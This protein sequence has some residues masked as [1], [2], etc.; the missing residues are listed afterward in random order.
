MSTD[1][2]LSIV[3]N[4]WSTLNRTQKSLILACK[5]KHRIQ[6]NDWIIML[7]KPCKTVDAWGINLR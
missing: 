5:K 6:Q 4:V 7:K 2:F 1:S 3:D